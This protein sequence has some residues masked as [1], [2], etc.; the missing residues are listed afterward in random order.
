[1]SAA[2]DIAPTRMSE[3]RIATELA[4]NAASDLSALDAGL[5][6]ARRT[7][8]LTFIALDAPVIAPTAIVDEFRDAP[9]VS[10]ASG[11]LTLVGVGIAREVRGTGEHRWAHVIANAHAIATNTD[12]VDDEPRDTMPTHVGQDAAVAPS[13]VA[14][15]VRGND[16]LDGDDLLLDTPHRAVIAGE[17]APTSSLGFA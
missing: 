5:V 9:L 10:W 8:G 12:E 13:E 11:D 14:G 6:I 16:R 1:M 2:H 7:P 15:D 4:A 17:L 3:P